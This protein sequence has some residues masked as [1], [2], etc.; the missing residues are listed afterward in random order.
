MQTHSS[1][2]I[3]LLVFDILYPRH[4][5][6]VCAAGI[7]SDGLTTQ[8]PNSPI[9]LF[10]SR[11]LCSL[12]KPLP[13]CERPYET[14]LTFEIVSTSGHC[15]VQLCSVSGIL[16]HLFAVF[17]R[18]Q[19]KDKWWTKGGTRNLIAIHVMC[20][21][22]LTIEKTAYILSFAAL[23]IKCIIN[24]SSL[25][26]TRFPMKRANYWSNW[27][28]WKSFE[29]SYSGLEMSDTLLQEIYQKCLKRSA[30]GNLRS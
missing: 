19:C 3:P 12:C 27:A 2:T 30:S 5:Q 6:M 4:L 28:D 24:R 26:L 16:N 23:F 29:N 15:W 22:R 9:I 20:A 10:S 7:G 17:W 14:N 11:S 18:H 13:K 25:F 1:F 21:V 8:S